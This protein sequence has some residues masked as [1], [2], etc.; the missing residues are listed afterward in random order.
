MQLCSDLYGFVSHSGIVYLGVFKRFEASKYLRRE[1]TIT[2]YDE[3]AK[4][5]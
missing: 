1:Y 5:L 4:F 2:L 3:G